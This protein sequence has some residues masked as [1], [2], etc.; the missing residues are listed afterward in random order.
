MST[1]SGQARAE[2]TDKAPRA[3]RPQGG[4]AEDRH[5]ENHQ[6]HKKKKRERTA[7]QK[8][9]L[10]VNA[11]RPGMAGRQEVRQDRKGHDLAE[12]LERLQHAAEG[13]VA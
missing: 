9:A 4:K 13:Q 3:T 7:G 5:G 8:S 11:V 2:A 6:G 10:R 1:Y 12:V